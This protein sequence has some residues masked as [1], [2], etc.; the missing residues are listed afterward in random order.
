[1]HLL[2]S[3]LYRCHLPILLSEIS[4]LLHG[5]AVFN[6]QA[7]IFRSTYTVTYYN[8]RLLTVSSFDWNYMNYMPNPRIV[9]KNNNSYRQI[10]LSVIKV[11]SGDINITVYLHC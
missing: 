9:N 5:T 4:L 8:M 2:V 3:E 10:I 11:V 1:V 6:I 7:E